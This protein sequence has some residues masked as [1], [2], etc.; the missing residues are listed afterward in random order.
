MVDGARFR[1]RPDLGLVLVWGKRNEEAKPT[2]CKAKNPVAATRSDVFSL[3][4]SCQSLGWLLDDRRATVLP[5]AAPE[6]SISG[7]ALVSSHVVMCSMQSLNLDA[8]TP[9]SRYEPFVD[10]RQPI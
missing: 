9:R 4:Q 3:F 7:T 8:E 6:S 1:R 10:G 5:Y 2:A